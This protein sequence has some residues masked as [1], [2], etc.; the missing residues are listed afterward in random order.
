MWH[1]KEAVL[2]AWMGEETDTR[3]SLVVGTQGLVGE[4]LSLKLCVM[5]FCL[6]FSSS[7]PNLIN[8]LEHSVVRFP[9]DDATKAYG[10]SQLTLLLLHLS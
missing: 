6:S 1:K 4:L 3:L 10:H 7:G 2:A 8:F 9:F 5:Q